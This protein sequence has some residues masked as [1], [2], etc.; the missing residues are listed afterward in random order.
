[1]NRKNVFSIGF[2]LLLIFAAIMGCSPPGDQAGDL[3]AD[4]EKVTIAESHAMYK[5]ADILQPLI[6]AYVEAGKATITGYET[7]DMGNG[8]Q[9]EVPILEFSSEAVETEFNNE[10]HEILELELGSD[11]QYF[12]E[13]ITPQE[14]DVEKATTLITKNYTN[15]MMHSIHEFDYIVKRHWAWFNKYYLSLQCKVPTLCSKPHSIK[16]YIKDSMG[17]YRSVTFI[18]TRNATIE[19]ATKYKDSNLKPSYFYIAL[20]DEDYIAGGYLKRTYDNGSYS[21]SVHSDEYY[22][23]TM[24]KLRYRDGAFDWKTNTSFPRYTYLANS[25][26]MGGSKHLLVSEVWKPA[27]ANIKNVV[28]I[29]A[30]QQGVEL[31]PIPARNA[32]TGQ[33]KDYD[34]YDNA[35]FVWETFKS[36]NS[37]IQANSLAGRIITNK[38][39]LGLSSSDTYFVIVHDACF[40]YEMSAASKQNAVDGWVDWLVAGIGTVNLPNLKNIYFGAVSRGGCL[41]ASMVYELT[42]RSYWNKLQNTRIVVSLF[43][44]VAHSTQ[45]ELFVTLVPVDNPLSSA[46]LNY[47]CWKSNLT[48]ELEDYTNIY[49]RQA[50]T[51]DGVVLDTIAHGFYLPTGKGSRIYTVWENMTHEDI[52]QNSHNSVAADHYNYFK[53]MKV[54]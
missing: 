47:F 41:A 13:D 10:M 31:L 24:H 46:I 22:A 35:L 36:K 8:I 4:G 21:T 37:Y 44:A 23:S 6:D 38:S 14:S 20:T 3:P 11:Y 7:I 32:A 17:T 29:L 49:I 5:V 53:S 12:S 18:G 42:R 25:Y 51:G 54:Y 9:R 15:Q 33:Y 52:G 45:G 48:Y 27:Q 1:M 30:G 39:E 19:I 34:Y 50:A 43:D 40:Y 2:L 26:T 28:F 16:L